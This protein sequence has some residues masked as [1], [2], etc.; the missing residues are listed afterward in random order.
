MVLSRVL[1]SA[2]CGTAVALATPGVATAATTYTDSV[3][4]F[5]YSATSTQG[6]FTGTA[7]GALPGA[8]AATVN[9]TVLSAS[10][11]VTGGSMSLATAVN[12]TPTLVGA[13]VAG[14]A[15]TRTN[16]S[17]TGCVN[18]YYG[19]TMTLDNL[20]ANG[21]STNGSG[22]FDGTLTHHRQSVFGTCVTY[23][24]TITGS[25]GVSF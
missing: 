25:L 8:W 4:G 10:G 15:V 6:K 7:Y 13:H 24:A 21:T 19:V 20:T 23:S 12:G 22:N 17:S 2:V 1:L 14:G 11:T 16:P 9:H 3:Y 5:E 18:Q